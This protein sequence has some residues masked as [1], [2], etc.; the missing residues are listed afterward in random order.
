MTAWRSRSAGHERGFRPRAQTLEVHR[1]VRARAAERGRTAI[2]ADM[3]A[4]RYLHGPMWLQCNE[5]AGSPAPP[6][7]HRQ[8]ARERPHRPAETT[9]RLREV[10]VARRPL[11]C[12][13]ASFPRAALRRAALRHRAA[14]RPGPGLSRQPCGRTRLRPVRLQPGQ[15]DDRARPATPRRSARAGPAAG[16]GLLLGGIGLEQRQRAPVARPAGERRWCAAVAGTPDQS[17]AGPRARRPAA[18]WA[19]GRLRRTAAAVMCNRG[20]SSSASGH[21]FANS[22]PARS[23]HGRAPSPSPPPARRRRSARAPAAAGLRLTAITL[24]AEAAGGIVSGSR[25]CWPTPVACWWTPWPCC[26]PGSVRTT[27]GGRRMR[28][29]ASAMRAWKCWSLHQCAGAV[30]P[31]GLDRLRG[32]A[33]LFQPSAILSGVML[34]WRWQT[35]W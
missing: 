23:L 26:S 28:A 17:A 27:R 21:D 12:D 7:S 32:R 14:P 6:C 8:A 33:A 30:R 25:P 19:G 5:S 29:A 24:V 13:V 3:P 16:V 15:P 11:R 18:I 9:S 22:P 34:G 2:G 10:L 20:R 1:P 4:A 31:G 35:C